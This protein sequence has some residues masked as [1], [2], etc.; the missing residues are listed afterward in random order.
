MVWSLILWRVLCLRV[1]VWSFS[2][3]LLLMIYGFVHGSVLVIVSSS[4]CVI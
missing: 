3:S 1:V 4:D 2:F